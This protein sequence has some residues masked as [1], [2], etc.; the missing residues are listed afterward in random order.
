MYFLAVDIGASSGRCIL[1]CVENEALK[2]EEVH[3]FSNEIINEKGVLCWNTDAL[4]GEI[5]NGMKKCADIGKIP[6]SVGIDT[7]GVDFVLLDSKNR[8]LGNAVSYRDSRTEDMEAEVSCCIP[9]GELYA[10]TGIQKMSINTI[11]QLMAAKN[12]PAPHNFL[13][14]AKKMLM[15]PDYFHFRL[16]GIAKTEYTNA[17]T[18]GLVSANSRNWDNE[19]IEKCGWI[20]LPHS[21]SRHP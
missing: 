12:Q 20:Q 21:S 18:T 5:I 14:Q 11:Y 9:G 15:L 17:T 2:Y 6:E 7:W 8:L 16:C 4:F 10:R 13:S 19:I 3:R 1:G